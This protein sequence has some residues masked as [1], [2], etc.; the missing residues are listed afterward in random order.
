MK[1]LKEF[2]AL[3][4]RYETI[5]LEEIKKT[6]TFMQDLKSIYDVSVISTVNELTGFGSMSTCTLC[7]AAK[8][9]C[10]ACIWRR[11]G[12]ES[13]ANEDQAK[14]FNRI[15]NA[16]CP[17]QLLEALHNRAKY[18]QTIIDKIESNETNETSN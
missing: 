13:C 7:I 16:R 2:K 8:N 1:N 9:T 15:R 17:K 14:T 18:M 5:T 12:R 3:K 11:R 10:D 6:G 4:K